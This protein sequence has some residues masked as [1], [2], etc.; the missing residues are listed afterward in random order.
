MKKLYA[1]LNGK[2]EK[3]DFNESH[4][5]VIKH[6]TFDLYQYDS[7]KEHYE[8]KAICERSIAG[9]IEIDDFNTAYSAFREMMKNLHK[10]DYYLS[11]G[12]IIST[13]QRGHVPF[14]VD[15][16]TGEYEYSHPE[17]VEWWEADG[18]LMAVVEGV[19]K[20]IPN[21]SPW[22]GTNGDRLLS[23]LNRYHPKQTRVSK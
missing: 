22:L 9:L 16:E 11:N 19:R 13:V 10:T 14:L 6:S 17:F 21:F 15:G 4:V 1:A 18:E 7:I 20:F 3:I 23:V 5:S 2:P 8:I 12:L